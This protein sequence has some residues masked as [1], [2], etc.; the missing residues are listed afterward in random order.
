MHRYRPGLG[1]LFVVVT[2]AAFL[3]VA[4]YDRNR[5]RQIEATSIA[6]PD[7]DLRTLVEDELELIAREIELERK[8]DL[9]E[10]SRHKLRMSDSGLGA[11]NIAQLLLGARSE[12]A[13][14]RNSKLKLIREKSKLVAIRVDIIDSK[15]N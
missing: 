1:R 7:N 5:S 13:N 12:M 10:K 2:C 14:L 8:I 9:F 11:E 6:V 3:F 15:K 4:I